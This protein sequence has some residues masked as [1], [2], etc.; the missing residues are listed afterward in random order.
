MTGFEKRM[1]KLLEEQE[2]KGIRKSPF[3]FG[4]FRRGRRV[5]MKFE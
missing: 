3:G 2:A 5:V 1:K 4:K